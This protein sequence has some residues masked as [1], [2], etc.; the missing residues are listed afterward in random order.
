[1]FKRFFSFFFVFLI[2]SSLLLIPCYAAEGDP[3]PI[4]EPTPYQG[5]Y[6]LVNTYVYGGNVVPG[7]YQ[8]LVCIFVATLGCLFFI[9]LPFL[10]V[11][12]LVRRVV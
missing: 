1:M 6:D 12:W 9:L 11:F 3:D 4:V 8:D 7:T 10:V 5:I 2:F